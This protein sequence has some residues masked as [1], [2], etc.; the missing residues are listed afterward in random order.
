MKRRPFVFIDHSAAACERGGDH[1]ADC[2]GAIAD[3]VSRVDALE[4]RSPHLAALVR[5]AARVH[6]GGRGML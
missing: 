5:Q 3:L 6:I 1:Y 2:M 4:K